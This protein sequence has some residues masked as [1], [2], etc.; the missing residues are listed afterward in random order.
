M[1]GGLIELDEELL[2]TSPKF[3]RIKVLV[4]VTKP[5][6]RGMILV[7]GQRKIWVKIKYE[8]SLNFC[9][10]CGRLGHVDMDC[11]EENQVQ[12]Q[13]VY[14]DMLRSSSMKRFS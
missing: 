11:D 4:D 12:D 7:I 8:R 14:G 9:Y 6:L 10:V 13:Q 5:L 2:I 1:Y 3:L